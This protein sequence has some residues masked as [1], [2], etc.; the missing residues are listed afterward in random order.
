MTI[1]L[2]FKENSPSRCDMI[3]V[4]RCPA[5]GRGWPN[6]IRG[7]DRWLLEALG[8]GSDLRADE[9]F[10]AYLDLI[11]NRWD[12]ESGRDLVWR[13]RAKKAAH[14]CVAIISDPALPLDQT[15]RYFRS[16][17]FH[18]DAVRTSALKTLL[19]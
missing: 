10:D 6:P 18:D 12:T 13:V 2:R 14:L 4:M 8:I 16:L 11:D 1:H 17:E 15:D 19:P 3:K 9:C 7:S 5:C